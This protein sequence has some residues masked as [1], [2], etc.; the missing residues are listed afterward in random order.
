MIGKKKLNEIKAEL[1][2]L[3]GKLPARSPRV[4]LQREI[5]AAARNP[6]RDVETLEMLCTALGRARKKQ[7]AKP[8]QAPAF[9][10][11]K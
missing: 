1:R 8:R 6:E 9:L 3:L 11:P 5:R 2:A 10:L 7:K 4:W